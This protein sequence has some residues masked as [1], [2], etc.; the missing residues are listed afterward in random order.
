MIQSQRT[1]RRSGHRSAKPAGTDL[2]NIVQRQIQ[3]FPGLKGT[4]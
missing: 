4:I 2:H 1:Q 3:F